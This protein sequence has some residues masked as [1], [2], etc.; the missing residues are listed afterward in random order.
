MNI[1]E[2]AA[3][4]LK[5]LAPEP[6]SLPEPET[7]SAPLPPEVPS[8]RST[9]PAIERL[10]QRVHSVAEA[11]MDAVQ[12]WHVDQ[13]VLKRAGFLPADDESAA[14]LADEVRRV[15]R[16]LLDNLSTM[17]AQ[18]LR[19][20]ERIVVTSAVPGEGKSFTAVN[21]ALSLAREPDFEVL[22][23]DGDIPKADI[24]R[25]LGLEER[26][27]LMDAL[28]N[29]DCRPAEL[30]VRTDVPNLLVVPAGQRSSLTSELFRGRRM[31][32]VLEQFSARN[33]QRLLVFDSS[34]LLATP[35]AQ[36]LASHMGQ[37]VIVV[38]A[39]HT[40]QH[41]LRAALESL[42]ASQYVGL[43]LNMSRLPAIEN[44]YYSH[45][46]QYRPYAKLQLQDH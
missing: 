42:S 39:G 17:G 11:A 9:G 34:P 41:E 27:G 32:Y 20:A 6:V 28:T 21:L 25:T 5:T 8:P 45:Y 2:K 29:E 12:P 30:V 10:H 24:T 36:V 1:V 15:K 16:P 13:H 31:Q 22:L 26:P 38:S 37:V 40:R 33:R 23:V 3:E 4:R 19:Y 35:E 46:S 14:R 18:A 44:H 7:A 43:L